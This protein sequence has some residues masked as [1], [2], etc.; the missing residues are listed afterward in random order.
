MEMDEVIEIIKFEVSFSFKIIYLADFGLWRPRTN[1]TFVWEIIPSLM[2]VTM[3]R[4][5]WGIAGD[6]PVSKWK[7]IKINLY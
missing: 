3:L 6:L 2:P 5:A 4:K 7:Y 1:K